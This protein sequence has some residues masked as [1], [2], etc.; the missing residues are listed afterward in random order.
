M[1]LE[2]RHPPGRGLDQRAAEDDR[3]YHQE[4]ERLGLAEGLGS[5]SPD[6]TRRA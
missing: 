2:A 1:G 3:V 5:I 4:L 6:L